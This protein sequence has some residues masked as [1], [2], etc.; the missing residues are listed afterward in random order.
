MKQILLTQNQ[1]AL[2]DDEDYEYLNQWR[3]YAHRI[4]NLF[5]A[6]RKCFCPLIEQ[7]WTIHMHRMVIKA[8]N[9]QIVDHVDHN[10]LN[11]QK[12]NLRLCTTSQNQQNCRHHRNSMSSYKGVR[13]HKKGKKWETYITKEGKQYYFG[14]YDLEIEAAKA[15][16]EAAK[17]YFGE[18]ACTNF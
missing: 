9:G 5:Y 4:G 1:V 2:V 6:K 16:D 11:N 3:W 17:K 14:L 7:Y 10:G 8:D 12:S 18:F 15:Y 13:W